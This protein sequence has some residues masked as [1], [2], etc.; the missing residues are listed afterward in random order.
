MTIS[1]SHQ[2][3]AAKRGM[4]SALCAALLMFTGCALSPIEQSSGT[5]I[6]SAKVAQIIKGKTTRAEVEA[7]LGRP[8]QT[9]LVA[10]GR[11]MMVYNYQATSAKV[12][13]AIMPWN[14]RAN[15]SMRM[16]TLQ[17]FLSKDGVVE[18]FEL[19]DNTR[20]SSS[21]VL[22]NSRTNTR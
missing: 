10:D 16:Q 8:D 19:S 7:L 14:L 17:I 4:L 5:P 15:V 20:N 13:D 1:S 18:D 3:A 2:F 12:N 21:D 11:R 6:D 9:S 22:G